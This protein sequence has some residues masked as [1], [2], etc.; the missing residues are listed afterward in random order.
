MFTHNLSISVEFLFKALDGVSFRKVIFFLFFPLSDHAW[1]FNFE[2]KFYP[3]DV[4]QLHE[5]LTRFVYYKLYSDLW[6]PFID[7][8]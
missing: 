2:V 1:H 3:T 5:D 4:H 8:L 6:L 7:S